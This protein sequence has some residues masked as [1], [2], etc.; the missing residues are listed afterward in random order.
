MSPLS[1]YA[2]VRPEL[3]KRAPTCLPQDG[4]GGTWRLERGWQERE[5][6]WT[7]RGVLA[8]SR[9]PGRSWQQG[10]G[11][12]YYSYKKFRPGGDESGFLG[13]LTS[14]GGGEGGRTA[15]TPPPPGSESAPAH[16][17][18]PVPPLFSWMSSF[19]PP[20]CSSCRSASGQP[21]KRKHTGNILALRPQ[22]TE[23]C[24]QPGP[25]LRKPRARSR[26]SPA[27]REP[28]RHQPRLPLCQRTA[29]LSPRC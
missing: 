15:Q 18:L 23:A 19:P 7:P 6:G 24:E 10:W 25:M 22:T 3:I 4:E 16:T 1:Y 12:W 14:L 26:S 17:G 29:S 13:Q 5:R 20:S 9:C 28:K 11:P 8:E 21:E 27:H 2:E